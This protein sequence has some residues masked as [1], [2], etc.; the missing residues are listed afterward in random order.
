MKNVESMTDLESD[1]YYTLSTTTKTH[2]HFSWNAYSVICNS[3]IKIGLPRL[4]RHSDLDRNSR[5]PIRDDMV[6]L[7]REKT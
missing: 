1:G 7:L 6:K 4:S 3:S 2:K 5:L